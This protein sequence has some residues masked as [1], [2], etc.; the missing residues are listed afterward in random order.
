MNS[1]VTEMHNRVAQ[2]K[3]TNTETHK[4]SLCM[5][6]LKVD[7]N[8]HRMYI[9]N[10]CHTRPAKKICGGCPLPARFVCAITPSP[11]GELDRVQP[12]SCTGLTN[13]ER[14]KPGLGAQSQYFL[15]FGLNLACK[16]GFRILF[17]MNLAT[18][19]YLIVE[20]S[21]LLLINMFN[22]YDLGFGLISHKNNPHHFGW[23]LAK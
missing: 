22:A 10:C 2:D 8:P 19:T 17:E 15:R 9:F 6:V 20:S 7:T 1:Q 18:A 14:A 23:E 4:A 21:K 3:N 13:L 11:P 5:S 16:I 12:W